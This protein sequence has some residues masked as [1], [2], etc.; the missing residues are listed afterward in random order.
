MRNWILGLGV[1]FA[2]AAPCGAVPQLQL[3]ILGGTYDSGTETIVGPAGEQ[4]TLVALLTPKENASDAEIQALLSRTYYIS[5]ALLPATS[6]GA[7]LG[8][9]TF[10]ETSVVVTS[11]MVFGVPPI[12]SAG[13]DQGH[14]AHDLGEHGVFRTF[15]SEFGFQFSGEDKALTYNTMDSPGGLVP[16]SLGDSYYRQFVIDTSGLDAGYELHFDLYTTISGAPAA[17]KKNGIASTDI[18]VD[19]FAPFSHDAETRRT[20]ELPEPGT[21]LLLGTTLMALTAPS[22]SRSKSKRK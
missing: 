5:V 4:I 1:T 10:D 18:D 19:D 22:R 15:F 11:D 9:F 6:V 16:S 17:L 21:L 12:E 7:E 3:D 8:S 2:V 13:G 14:D 20:T